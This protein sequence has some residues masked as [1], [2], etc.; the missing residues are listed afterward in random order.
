MLFE[1]TLSKNK[2]VEFA[3]ATEK[4][5]KTPFKRGLFTTAFNALHNNSTDTNP[6]HFTR[7][8]L[9]EGRYNHQPG[10]PGVKC[11]KIT[12]FNGPYEYPTGSLDREPNGGWYVIFANKNLG[13]GYLSNGFVQEEVLMMEC[14]ELSILVS[15]FDILGPM[16][17]NEIT[18]YENID[19]AG[20]ILIYGRKEV[21]QI[22]NS[23]RIDYKRVI[24]T[25]LSRNRYNFLAI[26]AVNISNKSKASKADLLHVYNKLLIGFQSIKRKGVTH[27]NT[28]KLGCGAFGNDVRQIFILT[29]LAAWVADLEVRFYL[30]DGTGRGEIQPIVDKLVTNKLEFSELYNMVDA[31]FQRLA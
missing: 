24:D 5:F 18:M 23:N 6:V 31:S 7:L 9:E 17:S 29:V 1:F 19:R 10:E 2:L 8:A 26:D 13:G 28:G 12:V 4:R 11:P 15:N 27:I 14:P 21:E 16:K 22:A 20:S 30:Y 25:K 3:E